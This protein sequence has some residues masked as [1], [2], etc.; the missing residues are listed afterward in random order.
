LL[1]LGGASV[2]YC[3][4]DVGHKLSSSCF[5]GME[6]FFAGIESI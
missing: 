2:I 5:R 1:E 4:D 3:E 6:T